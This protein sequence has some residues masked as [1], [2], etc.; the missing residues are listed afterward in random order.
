MVIVVSFPFII[1]VDNI[2]EIYIADNPVIKRTNNIDM[3]YHIVREYMI[4]GIVVI[5]FISSDENYTYIFIEKT[6]EPTFIKHRDKLVTLC[7]EL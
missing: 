6:P 3:K 5:N 7:I 1:I 4:K 2:G